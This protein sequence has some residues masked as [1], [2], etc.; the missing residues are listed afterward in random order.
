[1]KIY[2]HCLATC[3]FIF[4]AFVQ[5]QTPC[6]DG[7]AGSYPCQE[8]H[9]LSNIPVST[10]ANATGN[11]EGS[12]IWGWTDTLT[13]NEYAIVCTSNSTAFV[14]ITN[15]VNPVFL[16]RLDSENGGASVWRDVKVYNNHAFIVADNVGN[17]GMQV[18]DL[19][20][21]RNVVTPPVSF[22]SDA[23]YNGVGSCHNIIINEAMGYAYLV[24]CN[25]YS[26]GP[27]FIDISNPV[28]PQAAGG[29]SAYGYTH[30]AQVITYNGPDSDY[31]NHEILVASNGSTS[32]AD[33]ILILDVTDKNSPQ[34]ISEISYPNPGYAHQGWFT[35]DHRYFI[36]GDEQD[37]IFFGMN[38]R[39]LIFDLQDLDNPVLS[40]T[41]TGPTPSIDH[42]G[43]V[44]GNLFYLAN[45]SAGLRVLDITNIGAA[46]NAMTE[47]GYFDTLPEN[48]NVSYYGAWSVYP[49]FQSGN[50]VVNDT[51]RGLFII[52]NNETL[53]DDDF[54]ALSHSFVITPNPSKGNPI[55]KAL[56]GKS[57]T[58]L[59]VVN[60][61]GEV[62]Y[63]KNNINSLQFVL[64]LAHQNSGIYFVTVNAEVTKK[65]VLE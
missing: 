35:D 1:M 43:F 7:Y 62:V 55:V 52:S 25:A 58:S 22:T 4:N 37:E 32:G 5:A 39:T 56:N 34:F 27:V 31:T 16:G 29:Y 53:T 65:I 18:F 8:Y 28:S 24:G 38:T 9:L 14:D 15:P 59:K 48:N 64:P 61:L 36:F 3:F 30:D 44:N 11:P 10:L 51:N 57:I 60:T 40:S 63:F 17:H 12:D 49:Y 21:L 6:V 23:V 50:I 47:I 41:Y 20:R 42:N 2:T 46:T 13:G 19:T 54:Q 33:R 26:G 45:Y